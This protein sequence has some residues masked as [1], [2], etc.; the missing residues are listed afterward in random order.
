M[1]IL[2]TKPETYHQ[3]AAAVIVVLLINLIEKESPSPASALVKIL[4]EK[5]QLE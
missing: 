1:N 2:I 3:K 5:V 4:S